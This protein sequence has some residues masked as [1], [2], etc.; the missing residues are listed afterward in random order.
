MNI[1]ELASLYVTSIEPTLKVVGFIFVAM[2][3]LW[4]F[5]LMRSGD[6]KSELLDSIMKGIWA[7][8]V[9]LFT[10]IGMGLWW[11]VTFIIRIITIIFASIR[12]FFTSQV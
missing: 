11:V 2:I 1:E 5:S 4:L 12:D 3:A 10:Y 6:K 9:A 8:T 7:G